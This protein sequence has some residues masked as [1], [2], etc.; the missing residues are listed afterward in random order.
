MAELS[1]N[2]SRAD[3]FEAVKKLQK[4]LAESEGKRR[5]SDDEC[6]ELRGRLQGLT[7]QVEL[8]KENLKETAEQLSALERKN[9]DFEMAQVQILSLEEKV[10]QDALA[11]QTLQQKTRQVEKENETLKEAA[12]RSLSTKASAVD[13]ETIS[14]QQLRELVQQRDNELR[15]TRKEV[16]E[17]NMRITDLTRSHE[18][19]MEQARLDSESEISQR[20]N[21]AVSELNA[22]KGR[23]QTERR[24][25]IESHLKQQT[26][27]EDELAKIKETMRGS[28]M[29]ASME[30]EKKKIKDE[31]AEV[32]TD[33]NALSEKVQDMAQLEE[34][35]EEKD[36]QIASLRSRVQEAEMDMSETRRLC[37]IALKQQGQLLK[38]PAS[39]HSGSAS[40]FAVH[41]TASS[42]GS[43]VSTSPPPSPS[44]RPSDIFE[45]AASTRVKSKREQKMQLEINRLKSTIR[46]DKMSRQKSHDEVESYRAD[47]VTSL[48][49]ELE[50]LRTAVATREQAQASSADVIRLRGD[51]QRERESWEM[52][53]Q[54][55]EVETTELKQKLEVLASSSA[56]SN[57][58]GD[59]TGSKQYEVALSAVRKTADEEAAARLE[60]QEELL[61]VKVSHAES[62]T[63]LL[64][65]VD[66]L[67]KQVRVSE[68]RGVELSNKFAS[69]E[70]QV[71]LSIKNG[72]KLR[73]A[74]CVIAQQASE[75]EALRAAR[76]A[77]PSDNGSLNSLPAFLR[78]SPVPMD[79]ALSKPAQE[80][81]AQLEHERA[82]RV[83]A[84]L[85]Q[86]R[87]LQPAD[88]GDQ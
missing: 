53:R 79:D 23:W 64:A 10:K 25:M 29:W 87:D 81:R 58:A 7:D 39:S 61:R 51:F 15:N 36:V 70:S 66:E 86:F 26:E 40:P 2:S 72:Q 55:L 77:S 56:A 14:E 63:K 43:T 32:L 33:Y 20:V 71:A 16:E 22:E 74:E 85:Q 52:D 59:G 11:V 76:G 50:T 31:L 21:A 38:D 82:D 3:L 6:D 45:L 84:V 37:S 88:G 57:E 47:Y 34:Q 48:L 30:Q 1:K 78:R 67:K 18:A 8:Y 73:E 28:S 24:T 80:T 19:F 68:A 9:T 69:F 4:K 54:A 41:R 12:S 42:S 13:V 35:I 49:S 83:E 62:E 17:S 44:S 75:L 60:A 65:T 5:A 46:A 27:L